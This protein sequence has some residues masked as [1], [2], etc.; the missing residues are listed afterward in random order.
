MSQIIQS[1]TTHVHCYHQ[2]TNIYDFIFESIREGLHIYVNNRINKI[3]LGN[4]TSSLIRH[5][6]IL[7]NI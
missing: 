6:Q 5:R 1:N 2:G 4:K 7:D 3:G